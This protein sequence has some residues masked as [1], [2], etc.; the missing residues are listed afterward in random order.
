VSEEENREKF[1]REI[2]RPSFYLL[3]K[4]GCRFINYEQ[5]NAEWGELKK[6]KPPIF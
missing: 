3:N 5:V 1:D 4:C 2:V 6:R